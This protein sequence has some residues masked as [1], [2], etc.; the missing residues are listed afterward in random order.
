[1]AGVARSAL[2]QLAQLK[3]GEVT[4]SD[5]SVNI[6][7]EASDQPTA[8]KAVEALRQAAKDY[9]VTEAITYPKPAPAPVSPYIIKIENTGSSI[10]VTG[11]VPN[12]AAR[13]QLMSAIRARFPNLNVRDALELA[14][15]E[16]AS[17]LSCADAGLNELAR[18]DKGGFTITDTKLALAGTTRDEALV[19]KIP[20]ELRTTANRSCET[21]AEITYDAPPE[22]ELVWRAAY[23]GKSTLVIEGDVIDA[24]TR[25]AL[26]QAATRYFPNAQIQDRMRIVANR[27]VKWPVA[28]ELGLKMLSLLRQGEAVLSHLELLVR[29]EAKDAAVQTTVR[30]QITR[31]IP[32]GY[33]ARDLIDVRSDSMI[34]AEQ[35]AKRKAAEQAAKEKADAEAAAKQRSEAAAKLTVEKQKRKEE[36]ST[37]QRMMR[38]VATS[39]TIMFDWASANLNSSS[40]PTLDKLAEVARACPTAKIEIEGH[41]DAEGT[42]ERNKNLS[43]RRARAVYDYLAK[44]G[45]GSERLSAVGYGETQPIAPNDTAANRAK[46]RR[47]E[48]TVTAE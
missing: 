32:K 15:G 43:E 8:V 5:R 25:A 38:E 42:P 13:G 6:A 11:H 12:D 44:V 18:L 33:A 47:I 37:C 7:G 22:P 27:S 30:E 39:G 36:A 24:R 21:S 35:E 41:T 10:D 16:P 23:D 31:G 20:G 46:N 1:M 48:F 14:S 17:W 19:E 26:V 9:K 4:L 3:N 34:W 2:D 45:V 28:A 29:G 40:R